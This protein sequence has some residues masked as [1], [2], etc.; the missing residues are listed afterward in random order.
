RHSL[1]ARNIWR[2]E[3][4]QIESEH[5]SEFSDSELDIGTKIGV[6]A[7]NRTNSPVYPIK[8]SSGSKPAPILAPICHR[9]TPPLEFTLHATHFFLGG[10][11]M[12]CTAPKAVVAA[13]SSTVTRVA[14]RTPASSV[15]VDRMRTRVPA[16]RAFG[17]AISLSYTNQ[18]KLIVVGPYH[19][20]L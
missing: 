3:H 6:T 20:R 16:V 18:V 5:I 19:Y 2:S 14:T 12:S 1:S 17:R 4:Q 11:A 9:R 7:E 10:G 13:G 8:K 15:G